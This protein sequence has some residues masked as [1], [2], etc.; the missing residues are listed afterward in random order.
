MSRKVSQIWTLLIKRQLEKINAVTDKYEQM[1][2][3]KLG[4]LTPD[5]L[6]SLYGESDFPSSH[7]SMCNDDIVCSNAAAQPKH[8]LSTTSSKQATLASNVRFQPANQTYTDTKPKLTC[9]RSQSPKTNEILSLPN[10]SGSA[11]EKQN[12]DKLKGQT[13]QSDEFAETK[14][15]VRRPLSDNVRPSS[16]YAD[17]NHHLLKG[18]NLRSASTKVNGAFPVTVQSNV[19]VHLDN[20]ADTSENKSR[21]QFTKQSESLPFRQFTSF[22]PQGLHTSNANEVT[23]SCSTS[24]QA[25][26]AN[27]CI[28]EVQSSNNGLQ[29]SSISTYST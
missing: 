16:V 10:R 12:G 19:D 13:L 3:S 18:N 22:D 5:Q 28:P 25:A 11:D 7:A 14:N 26:S 15:T 29:S 2:T 24:L 17:E 1:A 20:R 21:L 6:L 4:H 9:D 27:M 8:V 23:P